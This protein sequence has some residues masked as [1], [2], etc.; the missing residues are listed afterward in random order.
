MQPISHNYKE[1]SGR[2]AAVSAVIV[3]LIIPLGYFTVSHHHYS[4]AL[5]AELE[6]NAH[7][8]SEMIKA[9]PEVWRFQQVNLEK[10][11]KRRSK[12]NE[13]EVRRLF[14]LSGILI[15]ESVDPLR[16]PVLIK[17]AEVVDLRG[18]AGRIEISRSLRPLM[19]TT[20][21]IFLVSSAFAG[22]MFLMLRAWPARVLD[23]ALADNRRFVEE[24]ELAKENLEHIN[25]A[26]AIQ[27]AE[28]SRSNEEAQRRCE[29]LQALHELRHRSEESLRERNRE[30]LIL[31]R[32]GET[33]LGSLDLQPILEQI[34][35]QA[36]LIG[37]FDV[38]NIRLLD[39]KGDTLEVAVSRGYRYRENALSHRKISRDIGAASR[40]GERIFKEPC[41]E[42]HVQECEGFR[43]LKKEGVEAFVM[44]PVRADGQVLGT[45]QLASRTPHRFHRE[46]LHLLETIGNHMGFAVQRAQ[47]YEQTRRQASELQHAS[48]LQADFSAMIAHDLRSPLMNITGI[49]ELMS[50]GTFGG[51]TEEQRKWLTRIRVN[52]HNL[53]DLVSDFLDVSKLESG[54]VDV[55]KEVVALGE[56]IQ[57]SVENYRVL[58]LD[59]NISITA[60][61]DSSLPAVDADPR[62]LDQVFSNLLSNAIKFTGQSGDVEVG[63]ERVDS[64]RVKVWVKDN[65]EGIPSEEIGQIFQKYRQAGNV[66]NSDQKG[67]G[68][69]LVICKMIIDAHGGKIWVDSEP[70]KG[71]TFYFSLPLAA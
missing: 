31:R 7:L 6:I 23:R 60:A 27:A 36:M 56:I 48:K 1:F 41:Y 16:R 20:G 50:E 28:L 54:Y 67:T 61:V 64:T 40:F 29:E 45:I 26:L 35:E 57:R 53:I 44:V 37:S 10:F 25:S 24:I 2:I 42:E 65:G 8:V 19:L 15:G 22:V 69:G 43:T 52:G 51:V 70:K 9:N 21:G 4:A 12:H 32:M 30:L 39:S 68:L 3:A 59:K 58:A 55:K 14:D 17:S 13:P 33:I 63:A 62:R 71:S 34:L 49:A 18:H 5:E 47:L 38:G 11:L 66:K 46:E